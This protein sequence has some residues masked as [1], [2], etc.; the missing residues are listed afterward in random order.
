VGGLYLALVRV[1]YAHEEPDDYVLAFSITSEPPPGATVALLRSPD[2]ASRGALC[3]VLEEPST[4]AQLAAAIATRVR[5]KG[6]S[7]ELAA[8]AL[9]PTVDATPLSGA[10]TKL[11]GDH[12]NVVHQL[13]DRYVLKVFREV[14]EGT[15]PEVEVGRFLR[16]QPGARG[17][18]PELLGAL[19]M[20]RRRASWRAAPAET[21][22]VAVLEAFVP[23]EGTAYAHTVAVL[24]RFFELV[25]T[26]E[27]D[28]VPPPL[29]EGSPVLHADAEPPN[30]VRE[31]MGAYRE[32]ASLL[33]RRTAELHALLGSDD[34][35]PVF[36]PEPYS[37]L[38]RRSKYQGLRNLTSA[39]LRLLRERQARVPESSR[40]DVEA[41]LAGESRLLSRFEPLVGRRIPALRIRV[42]GDYHLG[43]VLYTGKDF[44]IFD[45]DGGTTVPMSARRRK[46]S[47]LRDVAGMLHSL[48]AAAHEATSDPTVVREADVDAA[49]PWADAWAFWAQAAF[50]RGYLD[51]AGGAP[52]I[53]DERAAIAIMVDAFLF[54]RSLRELE[55]GLLGADEKVAMPLH[56]I[57]RM[58]DG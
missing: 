30:H 56:A 38:D 47:P 54:E 5:V 41:V 28:V 4:A 55:A 29:P 16:G 52:F 2:G 31:A 27:R 15:S 32:T 22:T 11:P 53:P 51:A 3:E 14:E 58:L 20:S 34:E 50:L 42:H 26:Q 44:V 57:A 18:T 40:P 39:V 33:G 35:D 12:A 8:T 1:E 24:Q 25:L 9:A 23:N 45:F 13:A 49:L 19:E 17:L 43:Q 37:A 36:A 48:R 46:R 6:S 21:R 10:A 7:G